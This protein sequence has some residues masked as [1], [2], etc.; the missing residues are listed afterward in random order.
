M[1]YHFNKLKKE[2]QMMNNYLLNIQEIKHLI[3]QKKMKYMSLP[4]NKLIKIIQIQQK[5]HYGVIQYNN[6]MIT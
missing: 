2:T 6:V 1:I 4:K 3:L 5:L